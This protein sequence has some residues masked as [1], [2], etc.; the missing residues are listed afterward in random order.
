MSRRRLVAFL[1]LLPLLA[2]CWDMREMN[3]LALVMAVGIDKA[4]GDRYEVTIQVAR[5]GATGRG[6]AGSEGGG[7]AGAVYTASA[8]GDTIFAAIRNLAQFTSRRIMWAHN[9]VVVIGESVAKDDITPVMDFFTRNQELRMRTWVVVARGTSARAI[10]SAKTGMEKVPADSISALFRYATLPGEAVRTDMNELAAAFFSPDIH[11]VVSALS[12]E[13]RAIPPGDQPGEHGGIDQAALR[14][15]A[16]I[17]GNRLA[18]YVDQDAGR[19]LLWLRREIKNTVITATPCPGGQGNMGLEIRGPKV[20]IYTNV[21]GRVPVFRVVV[22]TAAWLSEQD[23][24]TRS[25]NSFELKAYA[26][27]T[28]AAKIEKQIR[29]ALSILQQDLKT[30]AIYYGRRMHMDHPAWWRTNRDRWVDIFP[31]VVTQTDISV[32]V[33]KM[34]LFVRPMQW[35][36]P[37][38]GKDFGPAQRGVQ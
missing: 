1:L 18:G 37:G 15:T 11:P 8:T 9:N 10:V 27:R 30:D 3:Q 12:L 13:P 20:R 5:P 19:G 2:G 35:R 25:V 22:R 21:S 4:G 29:A 24:N 26:E 36:A 28:L 23:C 14:G 7:E 17:H 38:K 33:T 34:G 6:K 16:I 31:K 32:K